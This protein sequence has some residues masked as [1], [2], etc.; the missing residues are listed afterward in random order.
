MTVL[1][2]LET[3]GLYHECT[4]IHCCVAYVIEEGKLYRFATDTTLKKVDGDIDDMYNFLSKATTLI[5]HNGINF[6]LPVLKKLNWTWD[7]SGNIYDTLIIS[8][9]KYPNLSMTD[10]NRK[11]FSP[12]LVGS[13]SLKAWG[14]RVRLAKGLYGEQ[15]DAWDILTQDMLDYC[16]RDVEV[17]L[18]IWERFSQ[19]LPPEKAIWI[20]Q[21]FAKII[22]RQEKYGVYFDIDSAQKLHLEILEEARAIDAQMK[23]TFGYIVKKGIEMIPKTNRTMIKGMPCPVRYYKD[24]PYCKV[25]FVPFNP[26]SRDQIVQVLKDKYNWKPSN[27]TEKGTPI[28]NESVLAQLEYPE[29]QLLNK[30]L[31]IKKLLGQLS[32]G[33]NAWLKVVN[34]TTHRIHGRV[35][36][37][38]A[39]SRRCTHQSPNI[40]QVPSNR[41]FKGHE[42]RALFTVPKGKKLVGCDADALE[43]RTLSHY[44]ARH[45]GGKYATA[46]DE[47]KKEEG[48]DIHTVN[49]K[50][51]GL[52]TRDD[53]KTFIYAFLYGAGDAKIGTIIDGTKE[54]GAALKETFFRKIPAI[55]EL[56]EGVKKVYSKTKVLK[57]LDGNPYFIRSEHSALNTLLQGA[58]AL[59]MKVYLILLDQNLRKQFTVGK[60]Y[61]FV[62]NCHDEVQI[63]C[64]ED[65]SKEVA[66][67]CE[68]TFSDVTDWF[69]FRIPLRGQADIGDNWSETH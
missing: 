56:L 23:D 46:V 33:A 28:V 54:D 39:V 30:Y 66:S 55:K 43:L 61:E 11:N 8:K 49:Q 14:H 35:D 3:D 29:A 52:P 44:M 12:K 7:Y 18:K 21:E 60:Q 51:A 63:E 38:G 27:F 20:E 4:K 62:I 45:D 15:E 42:C 19:Q 24:V 65:I 37:L 58:G 17:L 69:D 1:F 48:T 26:G 47:G 6:D 40:A 13:H 32:D 34:P 59:V 16:V 2:D 68:D 31:T 41:A 64:D 22:S 67:I 10:S 36:T 9:L 25:D 50:A 53:A 57:A 5:A